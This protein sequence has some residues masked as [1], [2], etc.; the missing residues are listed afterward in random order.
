MREQRK[1]AGRRRDRAVT[2]IEIMLVLAVMVLFA[3]TAWPLVERSLADQRLR[4]AAD[5]ICA[6]WSQAR[7]KAMTSG[8][9]YRFCYTSG[10]QAFRLEKCDTGQ[11][12]DLLS[13]LQNSAA[14]TADGNKSLLPDKIVFYEGKV[15][16]ESVQADASQNLET[17]QA[18]QQA[19]ADGLPD[20]PIVFYPDGTCTSARLVLR[21]EYDRALALT[22]RGLTA[23][24][25]IGEIYKVEEGAL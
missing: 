16:D 25:A 7:A 5:M 3:A 11:A 10:E 18:D 14:A 21:N 8:A 1:H 20:A 17:I 13:P 9:A 24:A 6:E 22:I 4:D 15:I 2:L 23:A 12:A 19:F